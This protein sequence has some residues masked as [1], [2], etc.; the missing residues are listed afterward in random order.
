VYNDRQSPQ[1]RSRG[2]P[3]PVSVLPTEDERHAAN[4]HLHSPIAEAARR[5]SSFSSLERR[6]RTTIRAR[7]STSIGLYTGDIGTAPG[8]IAIS[9]NAEQG[10]IADE[11]SKYMASGDCNSNI[12]GV[13]NVF[14][15]Y[16]IDI[17]PG[18]TGHGP[19]HRT[20]A[21]EHGAE[22][23]G[24]VYSPSPTSADT[25]QIEAALTTI[26]QEV[27]AVN[28]VFRFHHPARQRQRARHQPETR[29]YIGVFRPDPT[30][31]P[32]WL[33]NL[34]MYK[35]GVNAATSQLFL[36]DSTGGGRRKTRTPASSAAA[37]RATG[38][39]AAI[40]GDIRDASQERPWRR[41]RTRSTGS[42]RKGRGRAAAPGCLSQ[43][44]DHA[45]C[46][47][48][49]YDGAGGLCTS[50]NYDLTLSGNASISNQHPRD[51]RRR[52]SR[53]SRSRDELGDGRDRPGERLH[54][55]PHQHGEPW[56]VTTQT[57]HGLA[58]NDPVRIEGTTP[59]IF[60]SLPSTGSRLE[61]APSN[62][63]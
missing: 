36:A 48:P 50:A 7:C 8:T 40:S 9:P 3:L 11:Y 30:R 17:L 13:Q 53:A 42:G 25:S 59:D 38:P 43:Q 5:T 16:T 22:R 21:E 4:V 34:K 54:P 47:T 26:F 19:D 35:L 32:R 6:R 57:A 27:Q 58:I 14:S 52:L 62:S 49:V 29:S 45:Q 2:S 55:H 20:A 61:T 51:R 60:N 46:L 56:T 15:T 44:P 63:S 37:R 39:P 24:Q 10:I 28:S 41:S 1:E 18:Q 23:Q 31:G 12:D 33:G